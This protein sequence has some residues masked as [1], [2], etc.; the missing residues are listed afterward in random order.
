MIEVRCRRA[1]V[2]P[3]R[4]ERTKNSPPRSLKSDGQAEIPKRGDTMAIQEEHEPER[5]RESRAEEAHQEGVAIGT[6][7]RAT[8]CLVAVQARRHIHA[9]ARPKPRAARRTLVQSHDRSGHTTSPVVGVCVADSVGPVVPRKADRLGC[10]AG[11]RGRAP[12]A[13]RAGVVGVSPLRSL[14]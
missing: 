5:R 4:P 1:A 13:G 9:R 6:L 14:P 10:R 8:A 2:D 12:G 11:R 7:D 3:A